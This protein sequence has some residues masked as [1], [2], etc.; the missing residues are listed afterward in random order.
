[1]AARRHRADART[2]GIDAYL[3]KPVCQSALYDCLAMLMGPPSDAEQLPA[4]ATSRDAGAGGRTIRILLADDNEVNQQVALGLLERYGHQV[5]VV[6]NG[7]EAVAAV[8]RVVYDLVLMDCQMPEMDGFRATQEIR[9]RRDG[10][11]RLPIVAMT[12]GAMQGDRER[13]LAAGMDD[14]VP[15]PINREK[16]DQLFRRWPTGWKPAAAAPAAEASSARL[17]LNLGQLRSIV[18]ED[19]PSF[20]KYLAL[21]ETSA[22]TMVAQLVSTIALRDADAAGRAAHKLKG[23][24]GSIGAEEMAEM[25]L[26]MERALRLASW[27]EAERLQAALVGAFG[28]VRE[29]IAAV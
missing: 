13:C 22:D 2:A 29:A 26:R 5:D 27:E 6:A 25:S 23:A 24:C 10:R 1:M 4:A 11:P 16:L 7:V 12:A 17:A 14:Y 20:R 9:R 28:R 21:F 19:P 8:E 15:K 18:G 3:A